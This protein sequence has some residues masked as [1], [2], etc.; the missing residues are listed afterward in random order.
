M[1]SIILGAYV[2]G[3]N[4]LL[5]YNIQFHNINFVFIIVYR[6]SAEVGKYLADIL[7]SR[8]QGQRPVSLIG[9]SLGARVIFFC[10][11]EMVSRKDSE[12]IIENV[13]LLGA[14][15]SAS[16]DRWAK[17]L[18]IISGKIINGY[19]RD[20]WLLKFMYRTSTA[21][22]RIA[23]LQA[24]PVENKKL[25]NKDLTHLVRILHS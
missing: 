13:V 10:L 6:R 18:P 5:S 16:T 4:H 7:L 2:L 14:P 12:G 9:F 1:L 21:T 24:I 3:S 20:D 19:C 8:Q 11:E 15:V 25:E 23:G 22:M 17:I